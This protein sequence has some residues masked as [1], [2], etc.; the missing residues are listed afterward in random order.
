MP[1]EMPSFAFSLQRY[2]LKF[3]PRTTEG[4]ANSSCLTRFTCP[5]P[6]PFHK[7]LLSL[8][9]RAETVWGLRWC[10]FVHLIKLGVFGLPTRLSFPWVREARE[11][12]GGFSD[13]HDAATGS[14]AV[15]TPL[16]MVDW[17]VASISSQTQ[18]GS[19]A[20]S[21]VLCLMYA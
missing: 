17:D 4:L 16:L 2:T 19:Q 14:L 1:T 18:T 15:G 21:I 12:P 5:L 20:D 8:Y 9:C 13:A 6:H 10:N 7:D 3:Q 11:V